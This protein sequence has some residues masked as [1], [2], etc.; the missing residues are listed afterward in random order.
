M[1]DNSRNGRIDHIHAGEVCAYPYIALSVL[2][3]HGD[4]LLTKRI[5]AVLVHELGTD[6]QIRLCEIRRGIYIGCT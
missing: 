3:E 4:S 5:F 6:D 1:G 2:T